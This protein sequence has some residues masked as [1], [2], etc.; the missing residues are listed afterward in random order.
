MWHAMHNGEFTRVARTR[1]VAVQA[2]GFTTEYSSE[3]QACRLERLLASGP[4]GFQ[5]PLLGDPI[6]LSAS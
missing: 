1:S 5:V 2:E 6:A 3:L 4:D